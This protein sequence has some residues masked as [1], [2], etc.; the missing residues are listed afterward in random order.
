MPENASLIV[1][2]YTDHNMLFMQIKLLIEAILQQNFATF[3][4]VK[5]QVLLLNTRYLYLT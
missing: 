4:K 2:N 3:Y 5:K 1:S